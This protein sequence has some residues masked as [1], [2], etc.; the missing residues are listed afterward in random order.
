MLD[1]WKNM[2]VIAK[3][4]LWISY[5][6][7]LQHSGNLKEDPYFIKGYYTVQ[8]I[9]SMLICEIAGSILHEPE[10]IFLDEPTIGLDIFAKARI[11]QII[12]KMEYKN[13]SDCVPSFLLDK[14]FGNFFV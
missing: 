11:R 14:D 10:I 2:G 3:Q 4:H 13:R 6:Y 9:S 5:A 1:S 7:E 8:D 12:K